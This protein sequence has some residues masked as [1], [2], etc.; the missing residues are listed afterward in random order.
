MSPQ[1][2]NVPASS[3]PPPAPKI[4]RVTPPKTTI[5]SAEEFQMTTKWAMIWNWGKEYRVTHGVT[6]AERTFA[7]RTVEEPVELVEHP[8]PT[9]IAVPQN[10][11]T[12]G[13]TPVSD[14][15]KH[16]RRD[17][18]GVR[19]VYVEHSLY[20]QLRNVLYKKRLSGAVPGSS[21]LH[22]AI[23]SEA[24]RFLDCIILALS[25]PEKDILT[26]RP[27]A[28]VFADVISCIDFFRS[29]LIQEELIETEE[30][31]LFVK[32][33]ERFWENILTD[34]KTGID[35]LIP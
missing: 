23:L 10:E 14:A 11:R 24:D 1:D 18:G 28:Y 4:E 17:A 31:D 3:S 2:P 21:V 34:P 20:T 33:R 22:K 35:F 13:L 32:D 6:A 29:Q 26:T 12:E 19:L 5:V 25:I 7:G 15:V 16:L 27:L 30:H 9:P 8:S